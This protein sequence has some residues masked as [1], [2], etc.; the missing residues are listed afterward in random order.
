MLLERLPD[1]EQLLVHFRHFLAESR[2]RLRGADARDHVLALGVDEVVAVELVDAGVRV[3]G[4]RHAGAGA[5]AHVAEHH[6]LHVDSGALQPGDALD[7]AVLDGFFA[8]PR[9][10]HRVDGEHQLLLGVLREVLADGFFINRLVALHQLFQVVGAQVGV[11][12]DALGFLHRVE[13]VLE[14]F[15]LDA[16]RGRAEHVDQSA[17]A[18]VG[19][20]GVA[21]LRVQALDRCVSEAE[22]EDGVHHPRHRERRAG[23]D[24]DEHRVLGV[25]ELLVAEGLFHLGDGGV[26]LRDDFGGEF[27]AGVG[28]G[29]ADFGCDG[30]AGGTGMPIL[31]ISARF[32]PLPPRSSFILPSPSALLPPKL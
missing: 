19:E 7:S 28:V 5:F 12:F 1:A 10:E 23:A 6:R 13:F 9:V 2:D 25:A 8:V 24:A 32:A 16:H 14:Q 11:E 17:V 21:G 29:G 31:H 18:V 4:E 22:V 20:A 30:E 3:A 27:L 15:V 26:D